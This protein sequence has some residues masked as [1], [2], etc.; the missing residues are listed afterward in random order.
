MRLRGLVRVGLV[1]CVGGC[2]FLVGQ[3]CE[4]A[5]TEE[6]LTVNCGIF[7]TG[8]NNS[9]SDV[10]WD[11][12]CTREGDPVMDWTASA[13]AGTEVVSGPYTCSTNLDEGESV[14]VVAETTDGKGRVQATTSFDA[15]WPQCG[16]ALPCTADWS[17]TLRSVVAE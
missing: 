16:G 7:F 4:V 13:A 1:L 12:T 2:V 14:L 15:L 5:D 10:T 3:G 8:I 9:G 11:I 6:A 17:P